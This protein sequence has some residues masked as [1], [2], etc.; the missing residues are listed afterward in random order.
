[1]GVRLRGL[2]KLNYDSRR[3]MYLHPTV[4]VTPERLTLGVTDAWDVG[5]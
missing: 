3:G 2:G 5:S 4:M 1:M